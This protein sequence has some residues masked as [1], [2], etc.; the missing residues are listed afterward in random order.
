MR[1]WERL[2]IKTL[3][4]TGV[5]STYKILFFIWFGLI[6]FFSVVSSAGDRSFLARMALTKSGFFQHVFGYFVLSAL[7]C[8]AFE[9][10]RLW[11]YLVGIVLMG[12]LFEGVQYV[13]P[14]RTFNWYDVVAN[15]AGVV[16]FVFIWGIFIS[17][18]RTQTDT[19]ICPADFAGQKWSSL[20]EKNIMLFRP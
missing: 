10:K 11:S 1:T 3:G 20:R 8:L 16:G 6:V 17:H 5:R 15:C 4:W 9:R 7:A 2:R 19:D 12:G 13:M 18:R 14:S